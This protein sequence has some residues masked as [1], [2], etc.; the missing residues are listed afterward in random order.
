[1]FACA[2]LDATT[3]VLHRPNGDLR[4]VKLT[5]STDRRQLAKLVEAEGTV[6]THHDTVEKS[7]CRLYQC[8]D[9]GEKWDTVSSG[10]IPAVCNLLEYGS[11]ISAVAGASPETFCDTWERVLDFDRYGCLRRLMHRRG[12]R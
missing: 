4:R 7:R 8:G 5:F 6:G 3:Q 9:C 12:V 2:S 10:G 11:P 1:M